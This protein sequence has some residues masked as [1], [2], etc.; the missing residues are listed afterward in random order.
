MS[1]IA[2]PLALLS[3][4]AT[5]GAPLLVAAGVMGDGVMKI[6]LLV[7]TVGWFAAAPRWLKGAQE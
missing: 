1:K 7:A 2:K 5:V 3:L 6:V 4:A